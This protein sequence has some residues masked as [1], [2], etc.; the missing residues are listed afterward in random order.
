LVVVF[1]EGADAL[2]GVLGDASG[3]GV[4]GVDLVFEGEADQGCG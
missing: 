2:V 3:I 4:E 1:L